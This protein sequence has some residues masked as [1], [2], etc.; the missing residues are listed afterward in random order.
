MIKAKPCKVC[1]TPTRSAYGVCQRTAGCRREH[2]NRMRSQPHK[3]RQKCT[4]CGGP[5]SRSAKWGFCRQTVRCRS[6]GTMA[7]LRNHADWRR[8]KRERDRQRY[9]EDREAILGRLRVVS[10]VRGRPPRNARGSQNFH[11]AGGRV[12]FC[13]T[14]GGYAGWRGPSH[15]RRYKR[16]F[17][18]T[19]RKGKGSWPWK[20]G[21][22]PLCFVCG[23]PT[24]WRNPAY[25]QRNTRAR[26]KQHEHCKGKD[27]PAWK[28]G[29]MAICCICGVSV[30]W[31]SL[32]Y[33]Q[34][35]ESYCKEHRHEQHKRCGAE[36][37]RQSKRAV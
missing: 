3:P 2:Q 37:G 26:C 13:S 28:G 32:K 22:V 17:C 33:I 25:I 15:L 34:K 5:L 21:C 30:T 18:E 4:H 9:A 20:G 12:V 7:A 10:R 23:K 8:T 24:K 6:L 11:W 16:F 31:R 14:C 27:N 1:G 36:S 29:R 35:H 19:H